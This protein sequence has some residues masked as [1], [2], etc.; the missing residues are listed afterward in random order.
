[1]IWRDK[2]VLNANEELRHESS[3]MKGFMQETDIDEYSIVGPDGTKMGSVTVTDHTA[4]K[5]FRRTV[6]ILQKDSAGKTIVETS[7]NPG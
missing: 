1:M 7:F 5:G 4:V 2:L 6:S 3:R